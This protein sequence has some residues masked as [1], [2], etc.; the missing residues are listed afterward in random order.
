LA[1]PDKDSFSPPV[2]HTVV[3]PSRAAYSHSDSEGSLSGTSPGTLLPGGTAVLP[4]N[5]DS[6]TET[7]K[8]LLN[9]TISENFYS[10]LNGEGCA[11]ASF[12]LPMAPLG[13]AGLR[14]SF[15]YGIMKPWDFA[16]NPV[17][18]EIVP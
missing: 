15:A 6:F 1:L 11:E 16:S 7:V 10:Q 9:S 3:V 14:I 12:N 18:I 5:W 2:L 4:L 17:T 13:A 8:N